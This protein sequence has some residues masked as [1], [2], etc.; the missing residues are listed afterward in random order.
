MSGLAAAGLVGVVTLAPAGSTAPAKSDGVIAFVSNR[1]DGAYAVWLMNAD[2][3]T[4]R[5]LNSHSLDPAFAA[6]ATRIVYTAFDATDPVGDVFVMNADGT[7]RVRLT[8]SPGADNHPAFSPAGP[9]IAFHSLRSGNG[10]IW[11][12]NVD[13][14]DLAPLTTDLATDDDPVFSP[15]GKQIAFSS[16]RDGT[17]DVY[18]MAADGTEVRRLTAGPGSAWPQAWGRPQER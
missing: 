14:T 13:G 16:G 2:G 7:N 8:D 5:R 9:K 17:I 12:M 11:T 3:A 18:V 6:D 4:P 1:G 15:D 10:D